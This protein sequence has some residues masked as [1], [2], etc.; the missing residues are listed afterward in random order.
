[1]KTIKAATILNEPVD[2]KWV[3]LSERLV[4]HSKNGIT[5]NYK[6]YNGEMIKQADVLLL[7]LTCDY[8]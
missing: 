5:Q 7:P 6:G 1:L 4:I 3:A 2:P 8:R